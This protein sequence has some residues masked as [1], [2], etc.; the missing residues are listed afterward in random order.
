MTVVF[1]CCVRIYFIVAKRP[2]G[3]LSSFLTTSIVGSPS[4]T[5]TSPDSRQRVYACSDFRLIFF[6]QSFLRRAQP[7]TRSPEG[8][9]WS[10]LSIFAH[11]F[12]MR[13]LINSPSGW[14]TTWPT[15]PVQK[16]RH[17]CAGEPA[18]IFKWLTIMQ[19]DLSL[20]T[21]DDCRYYLCLRNVNAHA[22]CGGV[23][24]I[25]FKQALHFPV[26]AYEHD[27]VA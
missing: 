13:P 2:H 19:D 3:W 16:R 6:T 9:S 14:H 25:I 23:V 18:N 22:A 15:M 8:G 5:C 26:V 21:R 7:K 4:T 11:V 1:V 10:S 20:T 27:I 12:N 24:V 17:R